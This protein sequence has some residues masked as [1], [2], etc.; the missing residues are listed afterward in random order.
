MKRDL[1]YIFY[2]SNSMQLSIHKVNEQTHLMTVFRFF[3]FRPNYNSIAY[4]P[5]EAHNAFLD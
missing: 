4:F 5:P 2:S 3:F 1:V